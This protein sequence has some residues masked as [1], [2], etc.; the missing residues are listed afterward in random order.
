MSGRLEIGPDGG[1]AMNELL[2][3]GPKEPPCGIFFGGIGMLPPR[4]MKCRP[5]PGAVMEEWRDLRGQA[6]RKK[7]E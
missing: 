6:A 7:G 5:G 1:G 3:E 4:L 2:R